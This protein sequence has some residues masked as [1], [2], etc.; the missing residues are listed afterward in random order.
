VESA[1]R[2]YRRYLKLEPTHAEEY[3]AYLQSKVQIMI[4]GVGVE[5][6]GKLISSVRFPLLHRLPSR[7]CCNQLR[8]QASLSFHV[9]N[10]CMKGA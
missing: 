4:P 2:V 9:S 10:S 5:R 8:S 1:L 7:S 3:I 6:S